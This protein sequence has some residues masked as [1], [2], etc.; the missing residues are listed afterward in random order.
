MKITVKIKSNYGQ[1]MIY[2]VCEYAQR[3]AAIARTKDLS[4]ETIAHIKKIG[5]AVEV[6]PVTL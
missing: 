5:F 6:Q 2:P 3:F 1:E 4:R